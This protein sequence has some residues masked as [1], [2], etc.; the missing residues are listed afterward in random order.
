[1]NHEEQLPIP[2]T[3]SARPNIILISSDGLDASHMSVYGYE[4][5]TTPFLRELAASSLVS[6]NNFANTDHSLGSETS[7]LT[8][9]NP[10]VTKVLFS[11]DILRGNDRFLHLP[12][13]LKDAGYRTVTLGVPYYID[14]NILNFH[15]AFDEINC[16]E[17][18]I[19]LTQDSW[20]SRYFDEE[21]Y[22]VHQIQKR[23]TDRLFHILLIRDFQSPI[24]SVNDVSGYTISDQERLKCIMGISCGC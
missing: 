22:F 2:I 12:G 6:E 1:M 5:D 9:R 21:R 10:V 20:F 14:A 8:G 24:A 4:R 7:V 17:K 13:I 16:S 18:G 3:L 19:T 11:P 15:D 23:V